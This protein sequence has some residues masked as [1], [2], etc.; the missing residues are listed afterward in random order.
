MVT[1]RL[2]A[3]LRNPVKS[4][5]DRDRVI[6]APAQVKY[7]PGRWILE[8]HIYAAGHVVGMD[9]IADLLTLVS[10]NRIF[11]FFHVAAD[12]VAQE[13]VQFHAR[14]VRPRQAATAE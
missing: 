4:F 5:Q 11:A 10:V 13:A 9:I 12:Q 3:D 2:A 6:P 7:G 8:E 1:H 14:M